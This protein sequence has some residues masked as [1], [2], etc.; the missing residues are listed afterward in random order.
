L[1]ALLSLLFLL[2]VSLL[3]MRVGTVTLTLTGLTRESA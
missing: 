2:S 3:I 1:I